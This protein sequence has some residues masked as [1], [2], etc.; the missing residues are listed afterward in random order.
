MQ[1][2]PLSDGND[3]PTI[4]SSAFR[5][6]TTE[7]T[8]EEVVHKFRAGVRHW[9]IA[10]L[11]GNGHIICATLDELTS[12]EDVYITYKIWPKALT[13]EDMV[14]TVQGQLKDM[15]LSYVDMLMVHAQ[16]DVENKAMQYKGLEDLKDAEVTKSL[17]VA[18]MS[19]VLLQDLLKNYRIPPT[20]YEMEATPFNQCADMVEYCGD[21][22]IVIMNLEPLGKGIKNGHQGLQSLAADLGI[23]VT[24]LMLRWSFT[25]GMCIGLPASNKLVQDVL[26]GADTGVVG[27][28]SICLQLGADVMEKMEAFECAL[29]SVWIPIEPPAEEEDQ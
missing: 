25:K 3:I 11:F 10:E 9:E 18:N 21:S 26:E 5:C 12:R 7:L 19:S 16:I 22:S 13:A 28:E 1:L 17:G 6:A 2:L 24:L 27:I 29:Q 4:F 14:A 8:R 20:V 23:S 15:G